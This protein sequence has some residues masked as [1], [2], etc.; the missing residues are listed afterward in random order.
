M[1]HNDTLI[2]LSDVVQQ[3]ADLTDRL[4]DP[5]TGQTLEIEQ[6]IV[7]L[8]IELNVSVTDEGTVTLYS[9][10]PTQTIET[11]VIPVFHRMSLRIVA[12]NGQ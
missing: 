10:P 7:N 3:L 8:P 9:S 4:E 6:V 12:T 5:N 2:S 1:N 11:T